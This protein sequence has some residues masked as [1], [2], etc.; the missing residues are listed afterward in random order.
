MLR[1][2]CLLGLLVSAASLCAQ[3]ATT[4]RPAFANFKVSSR[5]IALN[6]A[7]HVDFTTLPRQ[8]EGVDIAKVV[9]QALEASRLNGHWRHLGAATVAEDAKTRTIKVGFDLLPRKVGELPLPTIPLAWV[10]DNQIA[11]FGLVAVAPQLQIGGSTADLP[12]EVTGI[13][14]HLWGERLADAENR[15]GRTAFTQ[16]ADAIVASP[17]P[18]LELRYR[19]GSLGEAVLT[20]SGLTLGRARDSFLARWGAP[21]ED[22][23]QSLTWILG[24]TRITATP[25]EDGT[26]TRLHFVREDIQ[27]IL[28]RSR[29][30]REVF[31][32]LDGA[33]PPADPAAQ[34][35]EDAARELERLS[36]EGAE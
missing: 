14:G 19:E 4:T 33:R 32:I 5:T 12:N 1:L 3:S 30:G 8:V 35:R 36:N 20:T 24:W 16:T 18:G 2:L 34:R 15:L 17:I 27:A 13:A 25:T 7:V 11:E 6:Q 23:G 26:G 31:N 21:Q 29:V 10:G 28:D 22:G 9:R